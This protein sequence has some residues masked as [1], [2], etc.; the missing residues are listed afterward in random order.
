MPEDMEFV[1]NKCGRSRVIAL[2]W[3]DPNTLRLHGTVP[4]IEK[5]YCT[6]CRTEIDGFSLRPVKPKNTRRDTL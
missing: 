2:V 4:K 3:I 5:R 6:L 1:C